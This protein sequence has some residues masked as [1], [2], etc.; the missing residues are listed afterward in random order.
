MAKAATALERRYMLMI[1]LTAAAARL[2]C[3]A[4]V[5]LGAAAHGMQVAAAQDKVVMRI[6][7]TPWGMHG[8]YYAGIDQK[9]YEKEGIDLKIVPP[10]AGQQN[11]VFIGS[12][13]EQFG[14]ANVDSFVKAR[15]SGL[16][17]RAVMV[18]QPDSPLAVITLKSSGIEK[19]ADMR[20]KRLGRFQTTAISQLAPFL[21][22]GGLTA[23]D[24]EMVTVT[25]GAEVQLLAAG[26][27]DGIVGFSYGQAL[28]LQERGF[29]VNV[30]SMKDY[31]LNTYGTVIY[32]SDMLIENNPDLVRRFVKAT[33]EALDWTADNTREAVAAVIKV[34]PDRELDLETRKLD[35]IYGL[36]NSPDNDQV[37][38]LMTEEKWNS[39]IDF[40]VE[41]GEIEVR[42]DASELF[43]NE[44][45]AD[46]PQ[47]KALARKI[48][49]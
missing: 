1:N 46:L 14:V 44:F 5:A 29:A 42:P 30:M 7:F 6:N 19:P 37:F 15:A 10:S 34:A 40:Y 11:E 35:I 31:G 20:G 9:I 21:S 47:A 32:T 28:T 2:A 16:A 45:I 41:S 43:T 23:D 4:A 38:G 8:Q 27:V 39:T 3:V 25:R 24:V 12:G 22:A 36:Y 48:T 49:Q 17:V 18:D 26:E 33:V 13:R